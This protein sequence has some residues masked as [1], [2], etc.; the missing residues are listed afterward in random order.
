M[1]GALNEPATIVIFGASG[2]LTHRKLAPALFSLFCGGLLPP[3][4]TIVGTART[5]MS[6]EAFRAHLYDGVQAGA[7]FSPERC[8]RWDE[9]AARLRYAPVAYDDVES[10]QELRT[11]LDDIDRARGVAPQASRRLFHLAAP[12]QLYAPIIA[13]LGAAGLSRSPEGW[14]RIIIE[15]PFGHDAPSAGRLNDEVH[16]AFEEDSV[17]RIDHYL[18]KETVQNL[19]VLRFGNAIFEPLWNRNYIDNVQI[20][21]AETIGVGHRAGYYEKAGVLRDIVQNHLF[22]LLTIMAM[23]P[24]TAFDA[25]Y[26]RD[27]KVKVLRAIGPIDPEAETVRGQYRGYREEPGVASRSQTPTFA[28]L[29]VG[30]DNWRWR[31]VPFYLRAGKRLER[32]TTQIIIQFKSVPHIMFDVRAGEEISPNI[33]AICIQP[34]EGMLLRIAAKAP[35]AGMRANPIT[36]DYRYASQDG[37]TVLPD[38]YERL[39]LDALNG[40]A[41]L[42]ARC[43]E[44]ECAWEIIDPINAA[45]ERGETP[46]FLYPGD[47]WGPPEADAL[48]SRSGRAWHEGCGPASRRAR[49]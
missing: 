10:Y 36:L 39:L 28:A 44:I 13:N 15:K 33:L 29:K 3:G 11:V 9:F 12:A 35:G 34:D 1:N 25:K 22:Q 20:T 41:S 46:L 40:D 48:L 32:S 37:R 5:P 21:M 30:I 47:S 26:L 7:R 24:A 2:D 45:W 18:G 19:M 23:E 49:A 14:S 27:E 43:D 16:A 4:T 38:A 8:G 17:Y 42:F 6:D 31:G